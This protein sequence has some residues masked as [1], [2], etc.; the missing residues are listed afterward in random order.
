MARPTLASMSSTGDHPG[1][2]YLAGAGPGDIGLVTVRC[3]DLLRRCDCVVY[4]YLANPGLLDE[5]PS[6]AERIYVGKRYGETHL[7]QEQIN[8]IIVDAARRHRRVVRLKGGDP[9]VFGRGG[10]EAAILKSL[11]IPF[12]IVPG[13]TSGIAAPCYAG[14][15]VTDRRHASSV[16]FIT[17]RER[18]GADGSRHDWAAIA[19]MGTVVCY[20]GVSRL[21]EICQSLI[22]H[23]KP[24]ETPAAIIEWGTY[25]NQRVEIGTIT[26]LPERARAAGIGN[27]AIIVIGEVV[28]CRHEMAWY[29]TRPLF[30]KR[31]LVTRSGGGSDRLSR[32]LRQAGAQVLA[33]PAQRFE[34]P[35]DWAAVDAAI[36][37]LR[38]QDWV[39]FT[40]QNAVR[41][42]CDRLFA[43]GRDARA[44]GDCRI[45]AVGPG[46]G[47][48]LGEYG[49]KPDLVPGSFDAVHLAEAVQGS[50]DSAGRIL[51]PQADNARGELAD[52]LSQ[53]GWQ[54]ETRV[55]Y[56][57]VA[58]KT[59]VDVTSMAI[60]AVTFASAATVQRFLDQV[61]ES[62]RQHL[63]ESGCAFIAIGPRTADGMRA[64]NVPVTTV[65]EASTLPGLVHAVITALGRSVE[66][67]PAFLEW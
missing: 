23:G 22:D 10:E 33:H 19:K 65:A 21:A 62:G 48:V 67:F 2:V 17:G 15:P 9:L 12:E 4:D 35:D 18:P 47:N 5:V 34:P 16:A 32:L 54:V 38:D 37:D 46:T 58:L 52:T 1:T 29:D 66:G 3:V 6:T 45:A 55:A 11:G 63:I 44:F 53:A 59:R 57:A 41:F 31:V 26:D 36:A 24:A 43:T 42:F 61:G 51:L 28:T 20:M 7:K 14:I 39:A 27:P 50:G 13:V 40:S 30:G 8:D 49:L 25:D 64:A 56:R 60:D